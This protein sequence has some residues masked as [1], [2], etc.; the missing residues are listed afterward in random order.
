MIFDDLIYE[1]VNYYRHNHVEIGQSRNF[2]CISHGPDQTPSARIYPETRTYRCYTC[3]LRGGPIRLVQE[4]EGFTTKQ[5]AKDFIRATFGIN[6]K[7]EEIEV[8]KKMLYTYVDEIVR[9]VIKYRHPR[10]NRIYF[11]LDE[12]R[13]NE[14]LPLLE[15]MWKGLVVYGSKK[16]EGHTQAKD[17]GLAEDLSIQKAS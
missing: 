11:E 5:K 15:K 1:V 13:F 17:S 9:L 2:S 12:A 7:D 3:G 16:E 4:M 6:L 14:D 10:F 8:D